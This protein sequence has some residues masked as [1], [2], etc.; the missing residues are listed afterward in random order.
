MPVTYLIKKDK[1]RHAT[2]AF[3]FVCPCRQITGYMIYTATSKIGH[4]GCK[5]SHFKPVLQGIL[6]EVRENTIY[7]ENFTQN[8]GLSII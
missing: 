1:R 4:P 8:L 6:E 5:L 3:L 2:P 7:F